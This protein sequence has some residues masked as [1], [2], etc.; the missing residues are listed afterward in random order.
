MLKIALI[1]LT[2]G[3]AGTLHIAFTQADTMEGCKARAEVVSGI[4]TDAGTKIEAVRC[5]DTDF[6]FTP[7]GHDHADA[8]RR[9]QYHVTVQGDAI[10]DGFKLR[11]V[12]A[13]NCK[14]ESDAGEYCAVS[15]QAPTTE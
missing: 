14:A 4:L 8:D 13:G 2:M 11:P 5:G 12:E 6:T 9:W 1:V 10:E 3:E 7:Y 15:A